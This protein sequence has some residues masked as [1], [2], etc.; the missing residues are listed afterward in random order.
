MATGPIWFLHLPEEYHRV[1]ISQLFVVKSA[2]QAAKFFEAQNFPQVHGGF[3]GADDKVELDGLEPHGFGL[4]DAGLP[5]LP[6]DSFSAG[7]T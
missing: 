3:V 7:F 5:H 1:H 6:I 2:G 4:A